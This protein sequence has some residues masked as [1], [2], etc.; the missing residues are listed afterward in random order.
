MA[1]TETGKLSGWERRE[2]PPFLY[3]R[4]QFD[5]YQQTRAFLDQLAELSN[6]RAIIRT[7]ASALPT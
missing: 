5:A 3:R 7:A 2:Q 6:S 4:F 1:E